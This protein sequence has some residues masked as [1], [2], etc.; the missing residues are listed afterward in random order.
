MIAGGSGI[1]ILSLAGLLNQFS[2]SACAALSI[3]GCGL[4]ALSTIHEALQSMGR[5][6]GVASAAFRFLQM[7]VAAIASALVSY[8]S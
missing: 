3:F 8:L 2:F 1:L 6:T 7:V 4:M 5:L